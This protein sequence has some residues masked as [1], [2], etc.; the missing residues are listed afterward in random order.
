M[1]DQSVVKPLPN[2]INT[3]IHVLSGIRTHDPS[4]RGNALDHAATVIG[5][6]ENY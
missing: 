6:L 5:H 4:V 3:D 1:G 2:R